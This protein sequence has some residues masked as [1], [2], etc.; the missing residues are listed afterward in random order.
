MNDTSVF[1]YLMREA[2]GSYSFSYGPFVLQTALQPIFSQDRDGL[3][4]IQAFEGLVRPTRNG[5]MVRPA[6]FFP[7][8]A[9]PDFP[10]IDSRCRTLHIANLGLLHRSKA[11]LFV[12]FHPRLFLTNEAILEEVEQI[13]SA[14]G[15]AGMTPDRIVCEIAQKENDSAD[16]LYR[17][18]REL[19]SHGFQIAIDDFGAGDSDINRTKVMKPE[20]VKFEANW[21]K[22][23]MENSAGAALLRLMVSQFNDEGIVSIFEGLEEMWQVDLCQEL[24]VTL[25]QGYALS[26]PE[27]APTSFNER[28]PERDTSTPAPRRA[29][30]GL[31]QQPVRH[32]SA[33]AR[34]GGVRTTAFGKR[35]L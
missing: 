4:E 18:V 35:G 11:K 7:L 28:F 22:N 25:M 31:T 15:D 13:L 21:V 5:E 9:A 1:S 6:E 8:V 34:F 26:Q 29:D 23:F 14:T 17:F 33:P 20:F 12:N 3:L 32:V 27:L 24:G 2:E 30:P 19:H 16:M 10:M